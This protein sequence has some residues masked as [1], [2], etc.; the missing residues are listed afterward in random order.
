MQGQGASASDGGNRG[1]D[2]RGSESDEE[3]FVPR[4][5]SSNAG[6]AGDAEDPEATDTV[7]EA[8]DAAHLAAW[9][10]PGAAERLR[11]RFVTGAQPAVWLPHCH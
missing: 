8:L 3:L 1:G 4:Q 11:D 10:E 6:A 7:R 9:G 2:A 5:R